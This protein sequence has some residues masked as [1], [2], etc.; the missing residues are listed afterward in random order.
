MR[1]GACN[2]N[3]GIMNIVQEAGATISVQFRHDVVQQKHR[4]L[5]GLLPQDRQFREFQP[6]IGGTIPALIEAMAS[7]RA[8]AATTLAIE[9]LDVQAGRELLVGDTADELADRI[10]ALYE[11]GVIRLSGQYRPSCR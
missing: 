3:L 1:I 10:L 4:H 7:G 8:V 5:A 6:E 9:G 2:K 11:R